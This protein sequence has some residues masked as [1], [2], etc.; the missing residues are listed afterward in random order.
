MLH[1]S[2]RR[3]SEGLRLKGADHTHTR[4][5]AFTESQSRALEWSARSAVPMRA[6][7]RKALLRI[8]QRRC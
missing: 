2:V 3:R 4:A 6:R 5:R 1:N 7:R 8:L